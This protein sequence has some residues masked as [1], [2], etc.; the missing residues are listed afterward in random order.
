MKYLLCPQCG[1]RND[2]VETICLRCGTS[3]EEVIPRDQSTQPSSPPPPYN[4]PY[5]SGKQFASDVGRKV[6]GGVSS[7]IKTVKKDSVDFDP[8]RSFAYAHFF[9]AHIEKYALWCYR[10]S[11]AWHFLVHGLIALLCIWGYFE[12]VGAASNLKEFA[13]AGFFGLVA[14]LVVLAVII[15]FCVFGFWVIRFTYY[16]AMATADFYRAFLQ[17]EVNTRHE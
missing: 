4:D 8:D 13:S 7:F 14:L 5:A 12:G 3:L 9:I 10:I 15:A 16:M 17:I 11:L 1:L 2:V 6:S